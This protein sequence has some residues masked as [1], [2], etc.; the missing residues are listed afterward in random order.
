MVIDINIDVKN[1][2]ANI[3][4]ESDYGTKKTKKISLDEFL[5]TYTSYVKEKEDN[6]EFLYLPPG[7]VE[8]RKN[9]NSMTFMVET[10]PYKS[11]YG[12]DNKDEDYF[13][14][15]K[16][17]VTGERVI[18]YKCYSTKGAFNKHF[19]AFTEIHNCNDS[20]NITGEDDGIK[21][22]L[23]NSFKAPKKPLSLKLRYKN[24]I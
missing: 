4:E 13:L 10:Y 21:K 20:F 6:Y 2:I 3:I 11:F 5:Q 15:M 23:E 16:T 17:D 9:L 24:I 19:S 8:F 12:V 7:T 1:G 22:C 14:V 18:S